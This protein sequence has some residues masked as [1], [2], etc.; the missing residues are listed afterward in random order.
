MVVLLYNLGKV[1]SWCKEKKFPF[2]RSLKIMA[3]YT[4]V[5]MF[6]FGISLVTPVMVSLNIMCY[7]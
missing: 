2:S 5:H 3:E 4:L 1:L 7:N 6:L